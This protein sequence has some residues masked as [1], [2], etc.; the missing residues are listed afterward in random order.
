[1][2]EMLPNASGMRQKPTEAERPSQPWI[3]GLIPVAILVFPVFHS[4]E[5]QVAAAFRAHIQIRY[6]VRPAGRGRAAEA[7]RVRRDGGPGGVPAGQTIE[8]RRRRKSPRNWS[9]RSARSTASPPWKWPATATSTSVSTAPPTAHACCAAQ[10]ATAARPARRSSSSTPTSIRTRPRTSAI[11]AM[12]RWAT[13]SCACCAR[14]ASRVEVQNYIDNTGVQVADVVVGFH[15]LESKTPAEVQRA[16]RRSRRA[17]RLLLLGSLR[18]HVGATTRT[19]RKRWPGAAE[20]L[21][22]IEAG[23]GEMA[24]LAH[25]WWR[26]PSCKAHLAT[27]LRLD[28]EYDV[29]PRESE[30]LHLKF[31]ARAFELLKERKAI[32][33][34]TEG[35]NKGCWVMPRRFREEEQGDRALERHGHLR[36]QGHRLSALEIRPARQ[37]FLLPPLHDATPMGTSCG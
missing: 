35:K 21:H 23:E 5:K 3:R 32:Y 34:E 30:I 12:R 36:R 16:A 8:A 19:T 31:W 27:M 2:D 13:R 20:T 26:T 9:T 37:G 25:I 28:V 29:L 14:A 18:A 1:M 6:G 7:E 11:C 17:L 10:G 22:A 33:F 4:L 24:E 15:Y